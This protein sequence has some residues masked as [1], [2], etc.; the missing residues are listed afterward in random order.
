MDPGLANFCSSKGEDDSQHI[1]GGST[2]HSWANQQQQQQQ[3]G[4]ERQQQPHSTIRLGFLSALPH[5]EE[6]VRQV[7]IYVRISDAVL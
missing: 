7:W 4:G 5:K 2:S 6:V 3:P 1:S